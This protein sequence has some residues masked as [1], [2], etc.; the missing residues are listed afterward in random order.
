MV[1][2]K[3]HFSSLYILA[4][5]IFLVSLLLNLSPLYFF[6][7]DCIKKAVTEYILSRPSL[8][9]L[10]NKKQDPCF[11]FYLQHHRSSDSCNVRLQSLALTFQPS[12]VSPM[13][14]SRYGTQTLT[15]TAFWQCPGFSPDSLIPASA[16]SSTRGHDAAYLF[17][18]STLTRLT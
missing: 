3:T 5:Y 15:Y 1:T 10:Q 2:I 9:E 6:V 16:K 12:Q 11:L 18:F 17:Y 13:T 14:S 8:R 7:I 4:F